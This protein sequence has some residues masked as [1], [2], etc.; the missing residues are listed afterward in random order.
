MKTHKL[1]ALL[2]ITLI[3]PATTFA[4]PAW[5]RQAGA[6]C[7]S[8]HATPTMQLNKTGLTFLKNGHRAEATKLEAADMKWDHYFSLIWKGRGWY[9]DLDGARTGNANTQKPKTNLEQHSFALY[10]GG[11]IAERFSYFTE[12]YL[13]ENTGATSGAN[14][15]QGEAARKKLAEAF[16]QYN[17]PLDDTGDIFLAVRAGEILPEILHVFGVGAR[18]AEQRAIVLNEALAGNS[19]TYRPFSRQQGIDAKLNTKHFEIAAGVV[20]GS[21]TS[22]TNSIDAD[23]HKDLYAFALMNLDENESAVG[24]FYYKGKF[25]NYTVKQDFSTALL[26]KN[27]FYRAGVMGRYIRDNWRLVGTYFT[28]EETINA[29]GGKANNTG[30]YGLVDYNFN[31]TY[32]VFARYDRLDP[33]TDISNNEVSMVLLGFNMM[34]YQSEHSGARFNLEYTK[35]QTYLGGNISTA[36]A[37]RFTDNR[38]TAQVNWGF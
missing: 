23:S 37:T 32:G 17:H 25:S 38:L 1:T 2:A 31:D 10:T 5:S 33:N 35:K 8:C 27:D 12:I 6:S 3:A 16:I 29:T 26:Y 19:N 36:G 21:D 9:E 11:A 24:A 13:S 34:L 22:T 7:T 28:G 18:S 30:Y 20:N 4:I 14:I 15:V